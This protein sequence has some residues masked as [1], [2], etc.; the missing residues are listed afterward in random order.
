MKAKRK[1]RVRGVDYDGWS[2]KHADGKLNR[3]VHF[4]RPAPRIAAKRVG[5]KYVRVKIVEVT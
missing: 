4:R 1:R 5:G 3:Y 2:W